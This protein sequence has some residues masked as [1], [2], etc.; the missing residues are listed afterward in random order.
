MARTLKIFN[1]FLDIDLKSCDVLK[2]YRHGLKM[3]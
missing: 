2:D 3:R 1:G